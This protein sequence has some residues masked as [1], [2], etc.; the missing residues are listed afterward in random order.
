ML[1]HG[2]HEDDDVLTDRVVGG[3]LGRVK[4]EVLEEGQEVVDVGATV[5]IEGS[6][7][8]VEHAVAADWVGVVE[9]G[10]DEEL[11]EVKDGLVVVG[12]GLGEV[13]ER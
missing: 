8:G 4:E 2:A 6:D 7:G 12:N 13:G 9:S 11:E 1:G 10:E 5:E 3:E